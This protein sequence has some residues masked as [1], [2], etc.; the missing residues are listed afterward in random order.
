M[1]KRDLVE[2]QLNSQVDATKLSSAFFRLPTEVIWFQCPYPSSSDDQSPS[3]LI[4]NFFASA[5]KV[6]ISGDY[7]L[8]GLVSSYLT[9]FKY[10]LHNIYT[11]GANSYRFLGT[12][13]EIITPLL[14]F[15]YKHR[16]SRSEWNPH[17][18]II[19]E[20]DTWVFQRTDCEE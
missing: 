18:R 6:Q 12:T 20:H 7:L 19:N 1:N 16:G 17:A 5:S 11:L 14:L 13:K 10:R 3:Q 2:R 9:S 4:Q 15:G 8:L